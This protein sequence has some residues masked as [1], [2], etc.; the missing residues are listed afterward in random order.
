MSVGAR[1]RKRLAVPFGAAALVFA[2]LASTGQAQPRRAQATAFTVTST[3]DAPHAAPLSGSCTSTLPGGT[4]TLRAAVQAADF[5]GGGP[6]MVSLSVPGT[7]TLTIVGPNEDAAA[8]GDLDIDGTTVAVVNTTGLP[9]AI[10]GNL[11]DRVFSVGRR[12]P[13]RLSV[14]GLTI[15]NGAAPPPTIPDNSGGGVDVAQGS[16]AS[17]NNV[18][19]TGNRSNFA[20]GAIRNDGTVVLTNSVLNG[21]FSTQG[22]GGFGNN[23]TGTVT[24]TNVVLSGNASTIN[25]GFGNRGRATLTNVL[26]AA[27]LAF[28]LAG[29]MANAD[30]SD[31][32]MTNVTI[33]NNSSLF[34]IGGFGNLGTATLANVTITGN[35]AAADIGGMGNLG[36]ATLVNVDITDNTVQGSAAGLATG[37]EALIALQ[38]LIPTLRLSGVSIPT[39][40]P[41]RLIRSIVANNAPGAQCLGPVTSQGSNLEYPGHTCGFNTSLGDLVNVE[42]LLGPL[43]ANGGLVATHALLPGSPAID[44]ARSGC[45]PPGIDARGV[46]RPQGRA[47]D[48]GA[49]ERSSGK[50]S[51]R[52]GSVSVVPGA[53]LVTVQ[54][55]TAATARLAL[56]RGARLVARTRAIVQPG[57]SALQLP[58]P[59]RMRAGTY[60]LTVRLADR[61]GTMRVF[62]RRVRIR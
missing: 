36:T 61:I 54:A 41:T 6:H 10:D 28:G 30:A 1:R 9:V 48:I 40:G 27:N 21:N 51:A 22:D 34:L 58:I 15:Q 43:A 5:L 33:A 23:A 14:T 42:P 3:A 19:M 35:S 52:L 60:T 17:L 20:G 55:S 46:Q 62:T 24:L 57:F 59:A 53:V 45:P 11:T 18:I 16:F 25:G 2:L 49:Y 7:Y 47:C 32:T 56:M 29:G 31:I 12:A 26:I 44:A 4:C 13:G 38:P 8:T 50:L 39:P 37:V